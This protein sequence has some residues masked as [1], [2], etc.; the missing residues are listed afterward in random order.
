MNIVDFFLALNESAL[1]IWDFVGSSALPTG[2]AG[3]PVDPGGGGD[4]AG[5]GEAVLFAVATAGWEGCGTAVLVAAA[6]GAMAGAGGVDLGATAEA[7][8]ATAIF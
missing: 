1:P 3:A 7:G 4:T 2:A 5:G 8:P 6:D